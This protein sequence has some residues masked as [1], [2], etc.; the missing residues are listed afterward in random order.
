M[1]SIRLPRP[2]VNLDAVIVEA[3]EKHAVEAIVVYKCP[4]CLEEYDWEDEAIECCE[5]ASTEEIASGRLV[6]PQCGSQHDDVDDAVDCCLWKTHSP[7][8]RWELARQLRAF[9]YLLDSAL[10]GMVTEP[11]L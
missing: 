8:Q 3:A 5:E 9:G 1:L 7:A 2:R 6:C 4:E 11:P 10:V